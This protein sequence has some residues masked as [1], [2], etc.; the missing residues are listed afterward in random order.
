VTRAGP[1]LLLG[2]LASAQPQLTL[3][4]EASAGTQVIWAE[5]ST[6]DGFAA[7]AAPLVAGMLGLLA[8]RSAYGSIHGGIGADWSTWGDSGGEGTVSLDSRHHLF[9]LGPRVFW[10]SYG[11]RAGILAEALLDLVSTTARLEGAE[12]VSA[13]GVHGGL[14]YG[15]DLA[16]QIGTA[17]IT[18]GMLVGGQRRDDRNDVFLAFSFGWIWGVLRSDAP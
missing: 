4:G 6:A 5:Q 2:A 9:G 15:V 3:G 7:H 14:R 8:I 13:A 17:P 16:S 10:Q 1:A 18:F 12:S 11:M